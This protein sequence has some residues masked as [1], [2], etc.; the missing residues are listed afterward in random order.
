MALDFDN[1]QGASFAPGTT[2]SWANFEL[3][4]GLGVAFVLNKGLNL[5]IQGKMDMDFDNNTA[6]TTGQTSDTP[7]LFVPVQLGLNF[8]L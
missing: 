5:F 1:V 2:S 7:I 4:P 6:G 3:D 8:N